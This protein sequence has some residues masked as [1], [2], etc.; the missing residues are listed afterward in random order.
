MHVGGGILLLLAAAI[1]V[2]LNWKW[3][4]VNLLN[5]AKKKKP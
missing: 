3:I 2:M 1:H 4:Q 5:E